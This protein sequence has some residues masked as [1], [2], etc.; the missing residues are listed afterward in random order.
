MS[1]MWVEQLDLAGGHT[2]PD[3]SRS[4]AFSFATRVIPGPGERGRESDNNNLEPDC[5]TYRRAL[6]RMR[7]VK[8][9]VE[10]EESPLLCAECALK[11]RPGMLRKPCDD[12]GCECW[13]NRST[14]APCP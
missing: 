3:G 8:T 13:C 4:E 12:T 2:C 5:R 14:T 6:S 1:G 9:N 7:Q 10:Q 11:H